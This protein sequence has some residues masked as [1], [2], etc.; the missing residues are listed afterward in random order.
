[1]V[2]GDETS[3]FKPVDDDVVLMHGQVWRVREKGLVRIEELTDPQGAPLGTTNWRTAYVGS[4]GRATFA[5]DAMGSG[6]WVVQVRC[7]VYREPDGSLRAT[8][9]ILRTSSGEIQEG[10]ADG[11][12]RDVCT[13]VTRRTRYVFRRIDGEEAELVEAALAAR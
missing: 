7:L 8:R 12:G 6:L 9:D 3:L 1:M 4:Y 13:L 10:W 5:E 2:D 11:A